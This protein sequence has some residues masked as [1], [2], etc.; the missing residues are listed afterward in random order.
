MRTAVLYTKWPKLEPAWGRLVQFMDNALHY[1]DLD[2]QLSVLVASS[3]LYPSLHSVVLSVHGQRA[4]FPG[5]E[6]PTIPTF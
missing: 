6:P 2:Q 4:S 3:F 1:G 5:F